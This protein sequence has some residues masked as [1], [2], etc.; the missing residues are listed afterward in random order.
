MSAYAE[1]ALNARTHRD[2]AARALQLRLDV[3]PQLLLGDV[4]A[5]VD[6]VQEVRAQETARLELVHLP[7]HSAK[8][9]EART[10]GSERTSSTTLRSDRRTVLFCSKAPASKA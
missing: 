1:G 7:P 4:L 2:A 5:A 10:H 9:G 6:G 3:L 8:S